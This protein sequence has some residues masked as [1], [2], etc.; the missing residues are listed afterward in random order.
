[1][2]NAIAA[3]LALGAAA[4]FGLGNALEYREVYENAGDEL[5][6]A[7]LT[8]LAKRRRW[9]IGMGCDVGAYGLHATAL[10]IGSLVLVQPILP[11]NLLFALPLAARWRH[12]HITRSE[13]VVAALLCFSLALFLFR[14][15]PN[16]GAQGAPFVRWLIP[17]IVFGSAVVASILTARHLSGS[18]R[19]VCLGLGAGL[20]YGVN[21]ALTKTFAHLVTQG[22]IAVLTHWEPYALTVAT[23]TGL[24]L[25]QSMFQGAELGAGLP[26]NETVEPITASILGIILFHETIN[27]GAMGNVMVLLVA[28][29][30]AAACVWRLSQSGADTLSTA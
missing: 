23:F 21:S 28:A 2:R 16:E 27:V 19:A 12:R 26:I 14:A 6:P 15:A 20:C 22:P 30:T 5:D 24:W 13:I 9:L 29:L 10:A 17:L 18:H 4:L 25:A 1:V 8:R 11:L 3:L 7:L